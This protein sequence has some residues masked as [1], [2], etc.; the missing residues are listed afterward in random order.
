MLSRG[1]FSFQAFWGLR[2]DA[3]DFMRFSFFLDPSTITFLNREGAMALRGFIYFWIGVTDQEKNHA[4]TGRLQ[5]M[6][7]TFAPLY[8]PIL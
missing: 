1:R 7:S 6:G 2:G 4:L 8:L 3:H 5:E